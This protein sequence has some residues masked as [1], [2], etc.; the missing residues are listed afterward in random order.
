M[1]CLNNKKCSVNVV[2]VQN[3]VLCNACLQNTRVSMQVE[4]SLPRLHSNVFFVSLFF[5]QCCKKCPFLQNSLNCFV[6]VGLSMT[7]GSTLNEI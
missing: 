3:D 2:L 5:L 6:L 1:T 7:Y 4:I